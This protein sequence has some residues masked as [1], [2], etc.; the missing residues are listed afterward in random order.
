MRIDLAK[1]SHPHPAPM[2]Q[3]R[4]LPLYPARPLLAL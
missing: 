4:P 1:L 2:P 3:P